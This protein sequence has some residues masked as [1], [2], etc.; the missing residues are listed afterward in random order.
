MTDLNAAPHGGEPLSAVMRRA[1]EWLEHHLNDPG[2]TVV[3]THASVIRAAVL[4][5]M[6]A[7][8]SAFWTIDVEP[9]GLVEMTSDG[10]RW[11]LRFP[12]MA[13]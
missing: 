11:Q 9:F 8:P 6:Q 13:G 7:P 3:I 2:H 12:K 10:R 5:V 4:H 1:G